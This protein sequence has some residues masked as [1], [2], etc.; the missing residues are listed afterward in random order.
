MLHLL[1]SI[2]ENYSLK[3][4]LKQCKKN[5]EILEPFK[6]EFGARIINENKDKHTIRLGHHNTL[7]GLLRT[8]EKGRIQIGSYCAIRSGTYLGAANLIKIGNFVGI[9]QHTHIFD[10]NN[11]P[12]SPK[13]R[14]LHRIRV[15]PEGEDYASLGAQ[16]EKADSAPIIIEDNVWI[17][18]YC[19]I[20][21]GVTIGEGS[22]VARQSVVTKDVPPFT[23]VAGNPAREVK[24]LEKDYDGYPVEV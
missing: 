4:A 13:Q 1:R 24:K 18:M 2:Y 21:K 20:G 8:S 19:F 16:W 22:I 5:A 7:S 10:N 17:G 23:V 11:H 15:A 9:A 12:I 6:I 14:I 3:E